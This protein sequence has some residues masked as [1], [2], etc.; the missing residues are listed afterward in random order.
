VPKA[1]EWTRFVRT[2]VEINENRDEGDE[3]AAQ[4][5]LA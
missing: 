1:D 3:L 5:L 2:L 4:R